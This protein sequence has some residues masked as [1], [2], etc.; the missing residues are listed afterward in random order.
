[1][2]WWPDSSFC[3]CR[4]LTS[5]APIQTSVLNQLPYL[6]GLTIAHP[7]TND[8]NFCIRFSIWD[9]SFIKDHLVHMSAMQDIYSQG[10]SHKVLQ[11]IETTSLTS[12]YFPVLLRKHQITPLWQ[13][14][15]KTQILSYKAVTL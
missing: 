11:S 13:I 5:S 4:A 10:Y 15:H 6:N 7:V 3:A 9:R 14:E 8:E 1:M 12:Q 2:V